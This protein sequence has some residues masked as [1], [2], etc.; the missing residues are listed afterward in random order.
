[1]EMPNSRK[2]RTSS[3]AGGGINHVRYDH[4]HRPTKIEIVCPSCRACAIATEPR[5]LRGELIT[6]DLSVSWHQPEFS[7]SCTQC[8][9]RKNDVS[10]AELTSPFHQVAVAG[11]TLWAWNLEHLQTIQ[12]VLQGESIADDPYAFFATYIQRGWLQWRVR[13]TK[14][15]QRHIQKQQ[16]L[17]R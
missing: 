17:N 4:Q 3:R 8:F 1:M 6:S 7:V 2:P 14:E 15:I 11:R 9:Y 16:Q 10:Y 12:R 13:F 5:H